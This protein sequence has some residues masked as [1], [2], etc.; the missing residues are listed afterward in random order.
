MTAQGHPGRASLPRRVYR[1]IDR[2]RRR[3][4]RASAILR[5][6]SRASR[7]V[8]EQ[9]IGLTDVVDDLAEVADLAHQLIERAID[10]LDEVELLKAISGR[11]VARDE[12]DAS[13]VALFGGAD[14]AATPADTPDRAGSKVGPYT[15]G[16]LDQRG[17]LHEDDQLALPTAQA[18]ERAS[19]HRN[20]ERRQSGD[21]PLT[22]VVGHLI[23]I[24]REKRMTPQP[25]PTRTDEE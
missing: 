11:A 22:L 9:E 16:W 12:L 3:M 2:E 15:L 8:T 1:A 6:L 10:R 19:K 7:Y 13:P 24:P 14:P 5:C 20:S 4:A 17:V 25:V 21:P 18:A 23:L